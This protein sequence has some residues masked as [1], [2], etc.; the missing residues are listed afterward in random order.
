MPSTFSAQGISILD[1]SPSTS[2]RNTA[3]DERLAMPACT[4]AATSMNAALGRKFEL[5]D[6]RDHVPGPGPANLLDPR[7]REG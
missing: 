3:S 7:A 1:S 4:I 2:S 5:L 6:L